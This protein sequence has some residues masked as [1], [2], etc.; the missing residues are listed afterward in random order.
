MS[1]AIAYADVVEGVRSTLHTYVQALDDGRTDDIVATFLPDGVFDSEGVGTFEG[2]AAL[3]D[4]YESWK[5]R[6]PQRHLMMNTVVTHWN[7]EDSVAISDMAFLRM[8]AEGWTTQLVGRYHD[9]LHNDGG[10]WR[11]RRRVVTFVS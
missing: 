9:T 7:D 6:R 10:T 5:P 1:S 2:H 3:R 4:A 8:G 11:F